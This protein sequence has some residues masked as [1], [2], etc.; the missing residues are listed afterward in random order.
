M[1][2]FAGAFASA[3]AMTAPRFTASAQTTPRA[4][5]V[6]GADGYT[7][8][9][10]V[11]SS[12]G[13]SPV[14]NA[15]NPF[16]TREIAT[17]TVTALGSR[18][19]ATNGSILTETLTYLG[20]ERDGGD[21]H[22]RLR[23]AAVDRFT[24]DAE[25]TDVTGNVEAIAPGVQIEAG[26][27]VFVRR[28]A[29][30]SRRAIPGM[31]YRRGDQVAFDTQT[32]RLR[33]GSGGEST[34]G[35]EIRIVKANGQTQLLGYFDACGNVT[36]WEAAPA[37]VAVA[38]AETFDPC[39]EVQMTDLPA[40]ARVVTTQVFVGGELTPAEQA[41]IRQCVARSISQGSASIFECP[42]GRCDYQTQ[43]MLTVLQNIPQNL[44]NRIEMSESVARALNI[45]RPANPNLQ[46][47][48]TV[49]ML[50]QAD[51]HGRATYWRPRQEE[52]VNPRLI[53]EMSW[54]LN[55]I[56]AEVDGVPYR[57][58]MNALDDIEVDGTTPRA[59]GTP[60][61]MSLA[62]RGNE[63]LQWGRITE[64]NPGMASDRVSSERYQWRSTGSG[65]GSMRRIRN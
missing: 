62:A 63:P 20:A 36:P 3:S 39:V 38:A 56:E 57:S 25:W 47:R 54:D 7:T 37:P 32:R 8:Q 16:M 28:V 34:T 61:A 55:C 48:A 40:N 65:A 27:R 9:E 43:A 17:Q 12:L 24:G 31:T 46:I 19:D 44:R 51:A 15:R 64:D 59:Q 13:G 50:I 6:L 53:D 11:L 30:D 14:L 22:A 41:I 29:I 1:V 42:D 2:L 33:G 26:A 58:T 4:E 49:P 18:V 10:A 23:D 5:R 35:I 52:A 45:R 21:L 60:I